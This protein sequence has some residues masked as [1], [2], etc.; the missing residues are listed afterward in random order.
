[1]L[2]LAIAY[3]ISHYNHRQDVTNLKMGLDKA[4]LV[5]GL[6]TSVSFTNKGNRFSVTKIMSLYI[7]GLGNLQL[8]C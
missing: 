6:T 8:H 5:S 3:K 2:L 4:P 7:K 1:M